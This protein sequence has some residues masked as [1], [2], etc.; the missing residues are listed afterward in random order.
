MSP[1]DLTKPFNESCCDGGECNLDKSSAQPCGCDPG[2]K[3]LGKVV[4]YLCDYHKRL[5]EEADYDGA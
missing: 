4:G 5:K 1:A 2:M 3:H